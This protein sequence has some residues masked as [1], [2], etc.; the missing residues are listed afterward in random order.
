MKYAFRSALPA[1]GSSLLFFVVAGCGSPENVGYPPAPADVPVAKRSASTDRWVALADALKIDPVLDKK[2]EKDLGAALAQ[3]SGWLAPDAKTQA[4]YTAKLGVIAQDYVAKAYATR[5]GAIDS[6][7]KISNASLLD[8]TTLKVTEEKGAEVYLM[9][10]R[11]QGSKDGTPEAK[12]LQRAGLIVVPTDTAKK[13]PLVAYGH[14]GASGLNYTELQLIFAAQ[15][16][17]HVIVAPTFPGEPLCKTSDCSG[18]HAD[19]VKGLAAVP[20]INDVDELLGIQDCVVRAAYAVSVVPTLNAVGLK[21]VEGA[22]AE[23]QALAK[24]IGGAVLPIGGTD[25]TS[26]F[27][28]VSYI[29][30][31]SRGALVAQLA[32]AK[33]GG[34]LNG[35]AAAAAAGKKAAADAGADA[36]AQQAAAVTAIAQTFGP[37]YISPA[38]FVCALDVFGPTTFVSTQY[39]LGLQAFVRGYGSETSF[40]LLPTGKEL[41][42]LFKKYGE[43]QAIWEGADPKKKYTDKELAENTALQLWKAD[44]PMQAPFILGALRNWKGGADK[45]TGALLMVHGEKD[46]V[47]P[48]SQSQFASTVYY[49]F[50]AAL[51]TPPAVGTPA[52]INGVDFTDLTIAPPNPEL[53]SAAG[54]FQH[55]D[56]NFALGT[57]SKALKVCDD[58]AKATTAATKYLANKCVTDNANVIASYKALAPDKIM[59]KWLETDC[60]GRL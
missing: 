22:D 60:A 3:P 52:P 53:P 32:L 9:K 34:A 28:P 26:A 48:V 39:R 44:G 1:C 7:K 59:A 36:A 47:V 2:D 6:I 55:G 58:P 16:L 10:Y 33:T 41:N 51:S 15:Q 35:Y 21:A 54:R 19:E 23:S 57:A 40:A 8:R 56:L 50:N 45:K 37:K 14:G 46:M 20:Y 13:Y 31:T 30:G 18:K 4:A 27:Q 29:A 43:G 38:K 17:S 12:A 5:C 49:K 11:L 25:L 24:K 42:A